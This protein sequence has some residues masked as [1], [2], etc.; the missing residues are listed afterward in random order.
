[1]QLGNW[2]NPYNF[3]GR[4]IF[5]LGFDVDDPVFDHPGI[6]GNL[7]V[8]QLRDTLLFD[9]K[10]RPEFG[11]IADDFLAGREI[12]SEVNDRKI[13]I[14]GLFAMG[15]SFGI[16][17]ALVTSD[18]NFLRLFP[19]RPRGAINVGLVRLREG[20]DV[21]QARGLIDDTLPPD[22][23]VLTKQQF[24]ARERA[25]WGAT[26]PIGYVFAF[27]ATVGLLV[28]AI[29]V[30]QILF[31]DV[32]DH[33][34][35]YATLKAMGY[36]NLYLSG[37][38]LQQALIL[39]LLGFLPGFAASL[40]LYDLASTATRLPVDMTTARALGTLGVIVAMCCLSGLAAV[41]VVWRAD[42]AE[43]F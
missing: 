32:R 27:G 16:D 14:G 29:I 17:G 24:V 1:M 11:P 21:E 33:L 3:K 41:R 37:V 40:W 19:N 22:V 20:A 31:A 28:G 39:G 15:T 34:V 42:P 18:V 38:V 25:Y 6:L 8:I 7:D 2:K 12:V 4:R 36:S 10:S 5:V 30:Y 43:V 23:L 26:T 35:E 9:R 13:E